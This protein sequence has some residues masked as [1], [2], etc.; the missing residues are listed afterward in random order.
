MKK[1]IIAA[2]LA[3]LPGIIFALNPSTITVHNSIES[4]DSILIK[5]YEKNG[6]FVKELF[7]AH[8][9]S[10]GP[11]NWVTDGGFMQHDWYDDVEVYFRN[12]NNQDIFCGRISG[13]QI[14]FSNGGWVYPITYRIMQCDGKGHF[15]H[16]IEYH[17]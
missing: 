5:V 16:R 13:D 1:Y 3:L 6:K 4:D 7:L 15:Y 9:S 2:I 17:S 8:D 12:N 14:P 10:T 11:Y